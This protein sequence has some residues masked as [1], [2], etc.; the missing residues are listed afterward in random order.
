VK[1]EPEWFGAYWAVKSHK[2]SPDDPAIEIDLSS[3]NRTEKT[4]S[5]PRG[6]DLARGGADTGSTGSTSGEAIAA[7]TNSQTITVHTMKLHGQTIGE[8]VNSVIVPGLT[9]AW[10]PKGS[11]AIAYTE[12]KDGKLVLMDTQGKKQ[13]LGVKDALLP[14]WSHDAT[15]LAWLEKGGKRKFE[16]KV[17][18][19]K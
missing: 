11:K 4:T 7:A 12:P 16:L 18:K 15:E 8:F 2:T 9:F 19:I 14:M 1:A 3:E 5:V 17:A 10:A 13:D 6:G